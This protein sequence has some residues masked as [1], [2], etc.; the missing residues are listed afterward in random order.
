[1]RLS[2]PTFKG[3]L[4][5]ATTDA[6][7]PFFCSF[8]GQNGDMGSLRETSSTNHY[9]ATWCWKQGWAKAGVLLFPCGHLH[10]RASSFHSCWVWALGRSCGTWAWNLKCLGWRGSFWQHHFLLPVRHS[11]RCKLIIVT[12]CMCLWCSPGDLLPPSQM[13]RQPRSE[14]QSKTLPPHWS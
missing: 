10:T 2:L 11:L 7:K 8:K 13:Q 1:M 9:R 4:W 3:H 5:Q 12:A 6:Y 14:S